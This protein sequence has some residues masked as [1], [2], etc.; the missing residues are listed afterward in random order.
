[1]FKR[2]D[3][4]KTVK[5]TKFS[6]VGQG[7]IGVITDVSRAAGVVSGVHAVFTTKDGR[8]FQINFACGAAASTLVK[9]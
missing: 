3:R 2:G 6:Q 4:V 9:I 8:Q 1:M 5:P 7:A